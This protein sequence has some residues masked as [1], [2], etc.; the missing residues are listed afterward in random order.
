MKTKILN[1]LSFLTIISANILLLW[2]IIS[3]FLPTSNLQI[4][5]V[6]YPKEII[7]G[8]NFEVSFNL[9]KK[10]PIYVNVVI[11]LDNSVSIPISSKISSVSKGCHKVFISGNIPKKIPNDKYVFKITVIQELNFLRTYTITK[12]F[13]DISIK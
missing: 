5:D 4:S 12:S 10:T 2:F 9:C 11:E 13:D 7:Q 1:F 6:T 3:L 8:S